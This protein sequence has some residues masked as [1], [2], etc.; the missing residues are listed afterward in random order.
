MGIQ[1]EG[2]VVSENS[3]FRSSEEEVTQLLKELGALKESVRELSAQL[4]RIERRVQRS[5]PAAAV[6]MKKRNAEQKASDATLESSLTREQAL[7]IYDSVVQMSAEGNA[8][9]AR[10]QLEAMSLPDIFF[11]ARELGVTF[12]KSKPSRKLILD[13]LSNRIRQSM[14]LS[15][16]RT[17]ERERS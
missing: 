4:S 15:M 7:S 9:A 12:K 10:L 17:I 13:S 3:L 1:F 5:F 11:I 16:H 8:D 2:D 6:A 14:H